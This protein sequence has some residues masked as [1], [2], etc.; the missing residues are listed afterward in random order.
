[1]VQ[2][3][4][5]EILLV[6]EPENNNWM[7]LHWGLPG[8]KPTEKESLLETFHRKAR[9][10]VGQELKPEG[11]LKVE[12]LLMEGRTVVMYIVLAK[13]ASD[14]V[15]GEVKE[16]KW[17][18]KEEVEKMEKIE[19]TEYYNK[20]LLIEFFEAKL[21]PVPFGIF[22]TW[23]YFEMSEDDGYKKWFRSGKESK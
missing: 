5:N 1:M 23:N 13:A 10:D 19:F 12:E 3:S 15:S 16:Y 6:Q 7:P 2:N 4:K 18:G 20:D 11:I 9:T 21:K 14:E 17:V 22:R 8:G